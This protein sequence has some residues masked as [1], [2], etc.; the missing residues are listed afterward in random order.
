MLGETKTDDVDVDT[1]TRKLNDI[2]YT[3]FMKNRTKHS[4]RKSGGLAV[5]INRQLEGYVKYVPSAC[6]AVMWIKIDKSITN[7]EY[8]ILC[9]NVYVPP[10]G[11]RYTS[12]EYFA[13]IENEIVKFGEGKFRLILGDMNAHTGNMYEFITEREGDLFDNTH[14]DMYMGGEYVSLDAN[15][16]LCR[17]RVRSS[18]IRCSLC[19]QSHP[20]G[21]CT[22]KRKRN[23]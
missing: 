14:Y 12:P 10:E 1:I 15:V 13:E 3:I 9:G 16:A 8:D 18:I 17:A 4:V 7:L 6:K 20:A 23:D 21:L 22:K 2:G 5:V 19:S 11:S